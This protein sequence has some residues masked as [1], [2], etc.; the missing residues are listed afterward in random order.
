MKTTL[1]AITTLLVAGL[2][3]SACVAAPTPETIVETVV[4][5]KEVQVEKEVIVTREVEKEVVVAPTPEPEVPHLTAPGVQPYKGITLKILTSEAVPELAYEHAI[6]DA[7]YIEASGV[8][9][10]YE[11]VPWPDLVPKITTMCTAQTDDYDIFFMEDQ[12]QAMFEG[13]TEELDRFYLAAP[14]AMDLEDLPIRTLGIATNKKAWTGIPGLVPV[15]ILAYRTDLFEDPDLQAEFKDTY[16]RDLELPKTWDELL[17]VAQFFT[18]DMDGDGKNDSWGL[19]HRYGNANSLVSDWLIAFA[20]PRGFSYFD[21]EFNPTINSEAGIEAAKFFLAPEYLAVQPPGAESADWAE[22]MQAMAQG[23]LAMFVTETWAIPL[24]LDPTQT[25]VADKIAF[26]PIP[27]WQDP[28]TGEMHNRTFFV[29]HSFAINHYSSEEAKWAAWDYLNFVRGSEYAKMF[30]EKTGAVLRHS[31]LTDPALIEMYPHI[32][33]IAEAMTYP[34]GTRPSEPFSAE[35]VFT[36]GKEMS[37]VVAGD[38]EVEQAMND[39]N[40]EVRAIVERYGY[41]EFPHYNF[42]AQE[43]MEMACEKMAEL[44]VD[45]PDCK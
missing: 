17:E 10:A 12:W 28:D 23:R 27:S 24:L 41:Y 30:T 42:D 20:L 9:L 21:K 38:K 2:L 35:V 25:M 45:H 16:G 15:G 1:Q 39:A 3:I 43:R 44:G 36:V 18:R 32:P 37:S 8:D 31:Q 11:N 29:G 40:E 22:T 4:V 13:C 6:K 33:V 7:M 34:A 5:E 19:A 14:G 26:A